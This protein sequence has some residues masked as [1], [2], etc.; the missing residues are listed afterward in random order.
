[1]KN[2][3]DVK[4]VSEAQN[5]NLDIYTTSDLNQA[6]VLMEVGHS[7]FDI[8][9]KPI[10]PRKV[11]NRTQKHKIVFLFENTDKLRKDICAYVSGSCKVD[12]Q[13]L[14]SRLRSV[15]AMVNNAASSGMSIQSQGEMNAL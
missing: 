6:V 14:L 8:D 2:N 13:G 4:K 9:K 3:E 1:M 12:A 10:D 11:G 15:R 7:L 5:H